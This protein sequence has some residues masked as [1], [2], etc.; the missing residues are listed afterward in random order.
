MLETK[1]LN[2]LP[3]TY[4]QLLLYLKADNSLEKELNLDE[5]SR[6][7]S[8]ELKEAIEET[9]LPN[10]AK[11]GNNYLFTTLWTIIS[12]RD[13]KMVGD[14]CIIGE[15]NAQGEI[16]IG[17][18]T[19]EAFQNKGFMTEA[20]AAIIN[21]AKDQPEVFAIIASTN[22]DNTASFKVLIKNNFVKAGET[23]SLYNWK[24]V[25]K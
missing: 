6:I 5:T 3:L 24:L 15:P 1:R 16:E 7:I 9:I 8:P 17:Y 25:L 12:K 11:A 13:K 4:N 21:W 18:G 10:V 14:L 20:V 22:K 23:E 2:L 19:Y